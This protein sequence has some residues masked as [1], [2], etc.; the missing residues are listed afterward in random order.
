MMRAWVQVSMVGVPASTGDFGVM[1]GH[2]PTVA[3]LRPG[4][5]TVQREEGQSPEKYFVSSG[6]AFVHPDSSADISAVECVPLEQL[7]AEAA[8]RNQQSYEE[9]AAAA[10][11]DYE[12]AA[13]QIGAQVCSELTRALQ[14]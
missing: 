10:A 1:P 12:R 7:D 13:A 3:Q 14:G 2:I 4:V 5:L 9:K 8:K 6:F 11:D